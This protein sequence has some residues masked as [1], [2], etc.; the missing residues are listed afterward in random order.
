M[1]FCQAAHFGNVGVVFDPPW[2]G[3][4]KTPPT[5]GVICYPPWE[6]IQETPPTRGVVSD[7]PWEEI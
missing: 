2:E 5:G 6:G 7:P 1:N 4:Q 3:I